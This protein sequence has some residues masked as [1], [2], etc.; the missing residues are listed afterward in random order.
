MVVPSHPTPGIPDARSATEA[1]VRDCARQLGNWRD[2]SFSDVWRRIGDLGAHRALPILARLL[3]D[4]D[5]GV[6][7]G[8]A[9]ITG[10]IGCREELA[11]L[12]P[13]LDDEVAS[14]RE[15]AALAYA[16]LASEPRATLAALALLDKAG[17]G[18]AATIA[19]QVLTIGQVRVGVYAFPPP[20]E[21]DLG[22]ELGS[23]LLFAAR[24]VEASMGS[25]VALFE[26]RRDAG[27]NR[28]GARLDIFDGYATTRVRAFEHAPTLAE[29]CRALEEHLGRQC[30]ACAQ[31]VSSEARFCHGCGMS[32]EPG[33]PLEMPSPASGSAQAVAGMTDLAELLARNPFAA[34]SAVAALCDEVASGGEVAALSPLWAAYDSALGDA[35]SRLADVLADVL[36]ARGPESL[37]QALARQRVEGRFECGVVYRALARLFPRAMW[38]TGDPYL[39]EGRLAPAGG[40]IAIATR[41]A[42]AEYDAATLG[43]TAWRALFPHPEPPPDDEAWAER[44]AGF[45]DGW[46]VRIAYGPRGGLA[47]ASLGFVP[48]SIAR[49]EPALVATV[50]VDPFGEGSVSIQAPRTLREAGPRPWALRFDERALAV[51]GLVGVRVHDLE[52]GAVSAF[53]TSHTGAVRFVGFSPDGA[54]VVTSDGVEARLWSAK[55]GVMLRAYDVQGRDLLGFDRLGRLL[56]VAPAR[57]RAMLVDVL[58]G[59]ECGEVPAGDV[60]HLSAD[61]VPRCVPVATHGERLVGRRV[62]DAGPRGLALF[63]GEDDLVFWDGLAERSIRCGRYGVER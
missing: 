11:A 63:A 19:R 36:T 44:P 15:S 53:P 57:R 1:L 35:R 23:R 3:A 12:L 30:S 31:F 2:D 9:E 34:P 33:L 55:T 7:A 48:G 62:A 61:G 39:V 27:R 50:L 28:L 59:E 58:T 54:K 38:R 37:E 18:R 42:V 29:V 45:A 47:V 26:V 51:A 8:A 49:L 13:V 25:F 4:P 56:A 40:R 16:R 14:V 60:V 22:I 43:V 41:A 20:V 10:E 32:L 52:R 5:P 46:L 17:P 6:R 21:G 24:V